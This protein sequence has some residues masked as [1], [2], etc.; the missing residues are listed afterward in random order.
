V[1]PRPGRL[2]RIVVTGA[3]GFIGPFVVETLRRACREIC[4]L[5]GPPGAPTAPLP[6]DVEAVSID[7]LDL[8]GVRR[9]VSKADVVV[10][11]A[12]SAS[13]LRSFKEPQDTCMVHVAGTATVLE[14]CQLEQV[15]RLV[16][17]SSAEVYGLPVKRRVREN[18]LLRP[19]SPYGAAKVGAENLVNAF[20]RSYGMSTVVLRPFSIYG[21]GIS[22]TS[23]LGTIIQQLVDANEIVLSDLRPVRDYCH[24]RDL[25]EAVLLA[26]RQSSGHPIPLN[27]GTGIG[28]SVLALAKLVLTIAGRSLPIRQRGDKRPGRSDINRLIANISRARA[29]LGWRPQIKL[30]DGLREML[31]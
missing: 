6:A 14:A 31:R 20:S 12:G 23:V 1:R 7:I 9:A 5:V 2:S 15:N 18:D 28:T 8:G 26:C 3:G 19:R 10:H 17:I 27:I 29:T 24:A 11:M 13:V 30:S 21:P 25:A 16:Y 4:A 22:I